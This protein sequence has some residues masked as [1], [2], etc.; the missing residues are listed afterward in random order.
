MEEA[1]EMG[2]GAQEAGA[3]KMELR[4]LVVFDKGAII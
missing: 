4:E 1:K 2:N 3:G